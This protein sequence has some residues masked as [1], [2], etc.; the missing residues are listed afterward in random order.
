MTT[1]LSKDKLKYLIQMLRFTRHIPGSIIEVGVYQGG[2]LLRIAT[3]S[4]SWGKTVIGYDTFKGLPA[5]ESIDV[6]NKGEF[7]SDPDKILAEFKQ[8]ELPVTLVGGLFPD[9]AIDM[10]L[11]FCHLDVDLYRS[12]LDSLRYI[13]KMLSPGGLVVVDDYDFSKCPGVKPAVEEILASDPSLTKLDERQ[14]QITL[15]KK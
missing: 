4:E 9:S 7:S 12:T 8:H 10:S 15:V 2:T 14:W 5:P 13:S 1:L 6:L 11:S 3:E